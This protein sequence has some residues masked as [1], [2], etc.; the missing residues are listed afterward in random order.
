MWPT[1]MAP[2]VTR[3]E[4]WAT[5]FVSLLALLLLGYTVVRSAIVS[6]TID[7]TGTFIH[8]V[9]KGMLY[10]RT[11]DQMSA[12]HHLLNVW[13]MWASMKLFGTSELALRLPNLLAHVLYLYA[14]ARIALKASSVPVTI[15]CFLLLNVHPYLLDFFGLARGYGLACGL[16]MMSLWQVVRYV[17]EGQP[18]QRVMLAM[19]FAGLSA[20][21]HLAMINYLFASGLAFTLVWAR[22]ARRTGVGIWKSHWWT[23]VLC[24]SLVLCIILPALVGSQKSGS[25]YFGCDRFWSCMV[26]TLSEKALYHMP[27]PLPAPTIAGI[28][29]GV[30]LLWCAITC[31]FAWRQKW[32]DRLGPFVFGV[33]I[34]GVWALSIL[35]QHVFLDVPLPQTRTALFAIPM[36]AF[37][38]TTCIIAWPDGRGKFL[39]CAA[40]AV[41][42]IPLLIHQKNSFNLSYTVEWKPSGEIAHMMDVITRDHRPLSPELPVFTVH[43]SYESYGCMPYYQRTADMRWLT[44]SPRNAPDTYVPSDYYIVEYDGYDQVDTANWSLVYRSEITNTTLYRDEPLREARPELIHLASLDMESPGIKGTSTLQHHSGQH[45]LRFDSTTREMKPLRWIVPADRDSGSFTF[46]ANAEVLQQEDDNFIALVI[47]V[48]R[49][50]KELTCSY[51]RSSEQMVTFGQWGHV[52]AVFRPT[53]P[54][55]PGDIVQLRAWP[56]SP[57]SVMYLD[58]LELRI[59]Q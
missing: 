41:L 36:L 48:I 13:G 34:A 3:N 43:S 58:D 12:N 9:T 33:I 7:E 10:Q 38:V 53:V 17:D 22:Q 47:S 31:V 27:Y 37:L 2:A 45:G 6:F 46:S 52:G 54:L 24:S 11:F 42:C 55:L 4:R 59:L 39:P 16:M 8:Y 21:A 29:L 30:L 51:T 19:L 23:M 35:A 49:D 56:L 50:G 57:S 25:L 32:T 40:T 26:R 1:T 14:T 28:V 18:V 44:A 20:M 15:A 5:L